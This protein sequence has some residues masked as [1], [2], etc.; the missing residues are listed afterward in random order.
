MFP[1]RDEN[2]SKTIPFF[3]ILLIAVN[4]FA[5][6]Y[7]AYLGPQFVSATVREFALFP[8][9]LTQ[10]RNLPGSELLPPP[11]SLVTSMFL[12]A[13]ILHLLG[14]MW[15]L[16]IFGD[17]IED[18]VGHIPFVFFYV[19]TGVVAGL[20]HV[21]LNPMSTVPT[22][23]ASGAIS[24]I[25]GAYLILFPSIRIRTLVILVIYIT[26]FRIPAVVFLGLWF[27]FQFMGGMAQAGASGGRR[28]RLRSTYWR[29]CCGGF[30]YLRLH[31]GT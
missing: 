5:F 11:A 24:G 21:Y 26:T 23:G 27:A 2:P 29:I 16:W 13:G 6:G 22:V 7:Q 15:F 31:Q 14:N 25:L 9:E 19:L 20:A 4:V 28:C 8:F 30:L 1:L 10:F 17:N 3:T 18:Q 12:H